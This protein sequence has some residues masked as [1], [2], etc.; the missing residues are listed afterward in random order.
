MILTYALVISVGRWEAN[1]A[2]FI[3]Q[4]QGVTCSEEVRISAAP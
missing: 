2:C 1:G 4:L 3:S